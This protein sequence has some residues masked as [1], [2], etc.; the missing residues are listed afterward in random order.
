MRLVHDHGVPAL[1]DLRLP[2]LRP[3]LLTGRRR[4]LRLRPRGVQQPAQHERE[5]LQRGDDDPG[6]VDQRGGELPA[7]PVDG[8]DHALGVLDLVD[9]VLKLTV[10]YAAIGDDHDAIEDLAVLA[11]VEAREP[12]RQ[13][14]DAVGLA[15]PRGVLD[16]VVPAG[17]L[18]ARRGD[19]LPHRV[20]LVV[21]GEDQGLP[22]DPPRSPLAVVHLLVLRLD[23]H[24]VAEDVQ[25]ALAFQ[26]LF[27]EIARAVSGR[28]PRI[29]GAA[30]HLARMA[31]AVERQEARLRPA[32]A[33]A[34]V[35]LVRVRGEVH[36]RPG[37]ET[38]QRRA[39][40]AVAPVL[41]HRVAPA[42]A[43]AGVLQLASR[44]R[45][46]VQR[47]QQVHRIAF[48]RMAG[49]L[50]RDR[51]LV[52][53]VQRRHFLV[54]RVG[55][56]EPGHPEGLAVELEAVPQHVQR[57]LEV[58]LPGQRVHQQGF[59]PGGV[60]RPHPR[61]QLRLRRFEEGADPCREQGAFG[62]PL[63]VGDAPPAA[64]PQKN[65]LHM[66][67]E[68]VFGGGVHRGG[69][70]CPCPGTRA[71]F[72]KAGSVAAFMIPAAARYHGCSSPAHPPSL[73]NKLTSVRHNK[74][75]GAPG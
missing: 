29:A 56:L 16:Q 30:A 34:H 60:Q 5:L 6:A 70:G 22:R 43:G 52:L 26:H 20:E 37:L 28:V 63:G 41:P 51:Q 69:P 74:L 11:V 33:G 10:Q 46:A 8:L 25:E 54:Q 13:P 23:E 75:T 55:G 53:S 2:C 36:Q 64:L 21:A 66:A 15:A 14:G 4:L 18:F 67:L 65:F 32:D 7:V 45:Q 73:P 61:P 44:H 9:G 62:V 68:G 40:V 58:E 24:E 72:S 42:L 3:R 35:H 27:P 39:R 47:E 31:A 71:R 48:L 19:E 38:E 17:A 1:R 12:V 50:P 59:E 57:A 49:R